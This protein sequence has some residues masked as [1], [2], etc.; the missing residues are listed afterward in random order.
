MPTLKALSVA[1]AVVLVTTVLRTPAWAQTE[2]KRTAQQ[3]KMVKCN[4]KATGMKGD[5][6]KA[7]MKKCLSAKKA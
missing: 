4:K 6:R 2:N 3:E 5:E 1:V 7:F